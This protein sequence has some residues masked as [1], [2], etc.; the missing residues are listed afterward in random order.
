MT[1]V[2]IV[3]RHIFNDT[4]VTFPAA[5]GLAESGTGGF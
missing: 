4:P 3:F 1:R 5:P 2:G